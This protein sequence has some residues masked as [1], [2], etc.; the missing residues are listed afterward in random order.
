VGAVE[1][2]TVLISIFLA[3]D[4]ARAHFDLAIGDIIGSCIVDSTLAIGLGPIFFPIEVSGNSVL[5]TGLYAVAVSTIVVGVLTWR[6]VHDKRT[7]G[8][9]ILL[10]LASYL[11]PYLL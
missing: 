8:L 4:G 11:I 1:V 2:G 5:I 6:G 7:G 10:Y 9:F 3:M